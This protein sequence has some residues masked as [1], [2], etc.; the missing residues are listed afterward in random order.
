MKIVSWNYRGIFHPA[1]VCG[2]RALIRANN[3][4]I[5]FLSETES[6]PSLVSYILNHLGFYSMTHVAPIAS[7]GGLV[8]A[9][10]LGVELESFLT[11]K[12]NISARCYFDTPNCPWILSC[13]YMVP[14]KNSTN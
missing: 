1:A 12:N 9:W 2:L 7:S 10:R 4:N 11:N 6:P 13:I 3:P 5:L 8:L 14:L